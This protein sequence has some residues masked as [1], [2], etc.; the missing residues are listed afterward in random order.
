M[1]ATNAALDQAAVLVA[2]S[3]TTIGALCAATR[4]AELQRHL[5]PVQLDLRAAVGSLLDAG[6]T[7]PG[8]TTGKARPAQTNPLAELARVERSRS[9]ALALL[10][11]LRATLPK[12]EALDQ[13]RGDVL[14]APVGGS[15]GLVWGEDLVQ[16]IAR[17]ELELF[18]PGSAVTGARE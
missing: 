2:R 4:D 5:E 17:L 3:V 14:N 10:E 13:A 15:A 11:A 12:A 8:V 9:E 1:K 6:A 16:M 7:P 18:G